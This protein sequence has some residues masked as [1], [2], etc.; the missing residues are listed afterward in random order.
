MLW[1][2]LCARG[3]GGGP[4]GMKDVLMGVWSGIPIPIAGFICIG[5]CID[6]LCAWPNCGGG[7][8]RGGPPAPPGL[9]IGGGTDWRCG[10]RWRRGGGPWCGMAMV[11]CLWPVV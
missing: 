7:K 1:R 4:V 3:G 11:V 2:V 8:P 10:G 5:I 6:M 9:N